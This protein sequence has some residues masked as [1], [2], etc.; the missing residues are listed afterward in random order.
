MGC[1]HPW[2]P[3]VSCYESTDTSEHVII[4]TIIFGSLWELLLQW[5]CVWEKE[6][7]SEDQSSEKF[8]QTYDQRQQRWALTAIGDHLWPQLRDSTPDSD[9]DVI[10][11]LAEEGFQLRKRNSDSKNRSQRFKSIAIWLF[12]HSGR[13]ALFDHTWRYGRHQCFLCAYSL[14][15]FWLL[16]NGH[17]TYIQV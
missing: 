16:A 12:I 5:L 11:G 10:S 13:N 7:W 17:C 8:Y 4:T 15:C 2:H 3:S 9:Q 14:C 6:Q 1:A